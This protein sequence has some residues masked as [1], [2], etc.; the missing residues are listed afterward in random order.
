[1][2]VSASYKHAVMPANE[3]GSQFN[4]AFILD[5]SSRRKPGSGWGN[6][7]KIQEIPAFAGMT[8]CA[9]LLA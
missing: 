3:A 2:D 4:R 9:D 1:M 5:L 8:V 7:M 6:G